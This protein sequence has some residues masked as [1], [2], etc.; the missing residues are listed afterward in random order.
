MY[1]YLVEL[2]KVNFRDMKRNEEQELLTIL[3]QSEQVVFFRN[4]EQCII[5]DSTTA[6]FLNF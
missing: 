1:M 6:N 5:L 2:I 4:L 3:N